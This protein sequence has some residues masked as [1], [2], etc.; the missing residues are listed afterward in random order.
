MV[1]TLLLAF[2]VCLSALLPAPAAAATSEDRRPEWLHMPA[3][4]ANMDFYLDRASVTV[5][6]GQVEF[7]DVVIFRKP[8]QRDET[9]DRWIKEKRTL[10]RVRCGTAE[11]ALIRGASFDDGGHLIEAV[12]LQ[13]ADSQFSTVRPG[14]VAA[15]ELYR[16][17]K[18]AGIDVPPV[19]PAR[20][21]PPST[22][23]TAPSTPPATLPSSPPA[24][25]APGGVRP[26]GQ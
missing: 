6:E 19:L 1:G 4:D 16:A 20:S 7:W 22:P 24:T 15:S 25:A 17:C 23:A 11:Q 26:S 10:R 9:S 3:S 8:T 18:E 13:P 21:P 5:T 12:T 2:L 14:T